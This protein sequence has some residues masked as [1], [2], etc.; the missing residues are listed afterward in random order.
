MTVLAQ[1]LRQFQVGFIIL[2]SLAILMIGANTSIELFDVIL[3]SISEAY[4]QV[5]SFVAATLFIFYGTTR[6]TQVIR[7][8]A[9]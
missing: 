1:G 2:L 4:I 5:T 8:M 7:L 9:G 3:V 6:S